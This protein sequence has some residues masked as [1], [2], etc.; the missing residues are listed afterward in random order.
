MRFAYAAII[1]LVAAV[2]LPYM[3]AAAQISS[4]DNVAAARI[5]AEQELISSGINPGD[6][7]FQIGARNYVGDDCPGSGWNC[8]TASI[9]VQITPSSVAN[10]INISQCGPEGV[11]TNNPTTGVCFVSQTS[12]GSGTNDARCVEQTSD[13]VA[14][15][16]CRITQ[17]NVSGLNRAFIHQLIFQFQAD[18]SQDATQR[19]KVRQF[20]ATGP[21][22]STVFQT[23]FQ[24]QFTSAQGR[25]LP[26]DQTQE[27]H[28][29][30]AVCQGDAASA[31]NSPIGTNAKNTSRIV[32][33]NI[34]KARADFDDLTT[35][36]ITQKQ[37]SN[38]SRGATI[39]A[40]V[41][42]NTTNETN[43]SSLVHTSRHFASV[44]RAGDPDEDDKDDA[45]DSTVFNGKVTQI[46]GNG[47]T[48]DLYLG[49]VC[50]SITQ[51]QL[52]LPTPSMPLARQIAHQLQHERLKAVAPKVPTT[53]QIQHGDEWCCATQNPLIGGNPT[54]INFVQQHKAVLHTGTSA[55]GVADCHAQSS[56]QVE[57]DQNLVVTGQPTQSNSCP[58][59]PQMCSDQTPGC[60]GGHICTPTI[61]CTQTTEGGSCSKGVRTPIPPRPQCDEICEFRIQ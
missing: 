31:C 49:G 59:T 44:R 37:N 53:T 34:Q 16:S 30:A 24:N 7:V 54:N 29:D 52:T 39:V 41:I 32:Q 60:A 4:G 47:V 58:G 19:A 45:D 8:T 14:S 13:S 56:G 33:T 17:R 6:A 57:C 15:E 28:Q 25:V 23:I 22:E 20:N 43:E 40:G 3:A 35:A 50:G 2:T 18:G 11:V 10:P 55:T 36:V 26:L 9:V 48:C 42:Q 46:Q 61:H 12:T 27:A 38:P 51:N 21:N 5:A 1:S